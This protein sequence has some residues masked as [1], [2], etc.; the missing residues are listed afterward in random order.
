MRRWHQIN[1][2]ACDRQVRSLP[3]RIVPAVQAGAWRKVKRLRSLLVHAC[4][5]R[6]FAV[7]RVTENAGKKTPGV[8]GD[9]WDTPEKQAD[10]VGRLGRGQG[11]RP[12]PLK[13]ISLPKKNGQQRP[14]SIPTRADRARPA[15]DLQ[16][17]PP[18]AATAA[19]QNSDGFRPKRR[20]AEAIDPWFKILR[21]NTSATWSLEGDMPGFFDPMGWAWLEPHLPMH[22][23]LLATGLR[24]GV[25]ARGARFPTTAGVPHGGL[26]SPVLSTMG[27]DGLA[28][29]VQGGHWHR[30]VHPST[31]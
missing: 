3:R 7:K 23:R 8:E 15:V 13:R 10:A 12:A 25:V 16:A 31:L 14:L 6:A 29:V 1:W 26:L 2:A 11:E 17:L 22:K 4:A 20:C 28:A 18:I 19:D 5:A 30:R 24:R 21:Q 9:L 27:L